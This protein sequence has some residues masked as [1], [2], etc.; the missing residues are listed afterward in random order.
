MTSK[1]EQ[2]TIGRLSKQTDC[3][4]ETIRYYERISLLPQPPR[5]SGGHR[6]YDHDHLKRLNFIRRSRELGFT[7]EEIRKM[8]EVV[9]GEPSTCEE[10]KII[11]VAH[12]NDVRQKIKD[13][14]NMEK[15][16]KEMAAQCDGSTVPECP[17]IDT[18]FQEK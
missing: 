4:I 6:L 14:R 18:L 17:I 5:T 7:L 12:L 3:N 11:T 10:V 15:V 16:L 2:F 1:P 13:L 9:D 8:L